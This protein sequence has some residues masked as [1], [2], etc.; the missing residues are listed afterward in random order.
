MTLPVVLARTR[1]LSIR[2]GRPHKLSTISAAKASL[3]IR[4]AESKFF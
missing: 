2:K 3:S 1:V 4:Q